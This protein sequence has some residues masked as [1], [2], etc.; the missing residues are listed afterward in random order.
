MSKKD[1]EFVLTEEDLR[2]IN[3]KEGILE[4]L[5]AKEYKLDKILNELGYLEEMEGLDIEMI[6]LQNWMINS[7]KRVLIIFEGRDAAGKGG[8]IQRF[9]ENLMPRYHRV[10]ALP[11]PTETE[12]GQWYFQRY[13]N[14]LPT[15]DEIVLF[16][17]SWY[18]RAIVEPVNGFC[19]KEQYHHFMQQVN[20]FERMLIDDGIIIFKFWLDISKE[21]QAKRFENRRTD[22][23]KQ[24][25]IGPVDAKAQDLWDN[26]THYRDQMLNKTSSKICPWIFVKADSKKKTRLECIR[27]VLNALEYEG[28]ETSSVNLKPNDEVIRIYQEW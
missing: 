23:L 2:R 3:S 11:K 18:N 16:D 26:Y 21:E 6:K 28:K 22:P 13:I 14:Q 1:Q 5:K 17:R 27:Y 24:W 7:N 8:T 25:K 10:V 9:A 19:T 4:I 20:E 12:K 15:A